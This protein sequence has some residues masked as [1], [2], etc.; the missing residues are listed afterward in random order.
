ME[1]DREQLP[2]TIAPNSA[3]LV[4]SGKGSVVYHRHY[5]V[6]KEVC[7]F[8]LVAAPYQPCLHHRWVVPSAPAKSCTA[9]N[10]VAVHGS[11][12]G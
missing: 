4:H 2:W 11:V 3:A 9:A 10:D 8:R 12:L 7:N 6:E 1:A 5:E